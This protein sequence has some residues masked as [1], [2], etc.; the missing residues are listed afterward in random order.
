MK[1][2]RTIAPE[3]KDIEN[4]NIQ[5][6]QRNV[7]SNGVPV[8]SFDVSKQDLVKIELNFEAGSYYGKTE[9]LASVTNKLLTEGTKKHT[10]AEIA[11]IIDSYGGFIETSLNKDVASLSLYTLNK[12]LDK[13]LPLLA[14]II[15]EAS[16]DQREL[17]LH[18]AHKKNNFLVNQERVGYL[19]STRFSA[20]LFGEEHPYGRIL[21]IDDFEKITRQDIIDF[22]QKYYLNGKM[23]IFIAG[24][25]NDNTIEL[26]DSYLGD[27]DTSN[28]KLESLNDS[29]FSSPQMEHYIDKEDAVQNAIRIGKRVINRQH[30][31]FHGLRIVNTILGGYFGSRLMTNI[32]EDK[33]YTYGIG[34]GIMTMR[35]A[36]FF[37]ITSEVKAQVSELAIVEILKEVELLQTVLIDNEELKLVK[38]Y[39]QGEFQRGFDG[40]FSLLSRFKEIY[41]SN[42]DYNYYTTYIQK[43]KAIKAEEIRDIAQKYLNTDELYRLTVGRQNNEVL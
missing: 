34:S 40:P 30:P 7:L 14:E 33:G 1:L 25:L 21:N 18:M 5:Q 10:A 22:H 38:N 39:L 35:E 26:L 27:M 23:Q 16:F 20:I 24:K 6:P 28:T 31:D 13:T 29:L 9:L 42:L 36:A 19:A 2:D 3:I 41:Y 32:R 11:Y 43:V 12:Y 4:L 37:F 17:D 8:F 15:K